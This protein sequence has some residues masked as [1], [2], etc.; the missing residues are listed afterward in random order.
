MTTKTLDR[1]TAGIKTEALAGID[2]TRKFFDRTTSVLEERDSAF[3]PVPE[4]MKVA[5]MVAHVA[6]TVDWFREGGLE[7]RWRMDFEAMTAETDRVTSLAAARRWL[8]EA[9]QR[10]RSAVEALPEER[11]AETMADN[12]IV[13]GRPRSYVIQG[14]VDH[15]AHHRGALGVYARLLGRVPPM[16]YGED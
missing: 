12:P 9:W 7:D 14:I 13:P 16:V 6:Q 8:A 4:T 1:P 5:T 10:L 11:L 15:T 2:A 3:N